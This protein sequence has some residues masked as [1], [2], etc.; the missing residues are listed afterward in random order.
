MAGRESDGHGK[1]Y[2]HVHTLS[3][4]SGLFLGGFFLF[5]LLCVA[6]LILQ[7]M[8]KH[9]YIQSSVSFSKCFATV[10]SH[11]HCAVANGHLMHLQNIT[12]VRLAPLV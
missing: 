6:A 5:F 7:C 11:D 1:K 4:R 8:F 10:A 3:P 12:W 2:V 9:V